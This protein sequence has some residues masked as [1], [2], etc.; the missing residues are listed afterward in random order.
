MLATTDAFQISGYFGPTTVASRS[1][2][3]GINKIKA[4]FIRINSRLDPE[5]AVERPTGHTGRHSFSGAINSKV[6]C[7]VVA[8]A[9]K[10]HDSASLQRYNH[11]DEGQKVV[12]ALAIAAMSSATND[13]DEYRVANFNGS[14]VR[15]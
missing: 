7:E 15:I 8:N 5:F 14:S 12:P 1:I 3:K 6:S 4:A 11:P 13:S 2:R 10:R 9:S